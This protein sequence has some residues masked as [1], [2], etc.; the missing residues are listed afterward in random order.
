VEIINIFRKSKMAA[1]AILDFFLKLAY[2]T[3]GSI[4]AGT[5]CSL[6]KSGENCFIHV[7]IINIFRKSKMAAAVI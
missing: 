6:L 2:L 4:P 5:R 3:H 7:E 1:A